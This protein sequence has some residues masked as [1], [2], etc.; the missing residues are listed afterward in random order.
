MRTAGLPGI[1]PAGRDLRPRAGD[2]QPLGPQSGDFH[3]GSTL[4]HEM[5][6]VYTLRRTRH[7]V[8]RWFSEGISVFEEWTTGPTPGMAVGPA[9]ARTFTAGKLLPIAKLDGGF[10]RPSYEQQVQVVLH[11]GRPDLPVR[12]AALRLGEAGGS[13]CARSTTIQTTAQASRAVFK[14]EPET[15]RQAIRRIHEPAI[16]RPTWPTQALD[17]ADGAR[18]PP[19]G[20]AQL[21]RAR[22]MR[23]RPP[24]RSCPEFTEERQPL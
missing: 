22:A 2:G 7:R 6:H 14:V 20:G 23:R 10:I 17:R 15:V 19:A 8:P 12:R 5:A 11:A 4:W 13:S 9:G 24:S 1:G 3:W 21:G 16:R 18:A